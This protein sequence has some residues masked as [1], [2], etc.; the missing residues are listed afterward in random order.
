M[1]GAS[2]NDLDLLAGSGGSAERGRL[3]V[4]GSYKLHGESYAIPGN[5]IWKL[6]EEQTHLREEIHGFSW[7][8]DLRGD[9]GA[10]AF[11]LAQRWLFEW[12]AR[13]SGHRNTPFSPQITGRRLVHWLRNSRMLLAMRNARQLDQF[14]R[15]VSAHAE[16]LRRRRLVAER[17]LPRIEALAGRICAEVAIGTS[18]P[19]LSR[20]ADALA[21]ECRSAISGA[22][23]IASRNPEEL[24]RI[25]QNLTWA[26]AA[27]DA[28]KCLPG[29]DHRNG[30]EI[31]SGILRSLRHSS[32]AMPRFHGGGD[33]QVG[34]VDQ[35]IAHS[36]SGRLARLDAVM[37]YTRLRAGKTTA[38]VDVAAPPTRSA[39]RNAHASTLAFEAVSGG[40]PLIVNSGPGTGFGPDQVQAARAT[41]AHSSVEIAGVPSSRLASPVL[42]MPYRDQELSSVP[43]KV[44]VSQLPGRNGQTVIA[45]HDGYADMFG[46]T[47]MRRIDLGRAGKRLWGEDTVWTKSETDRLAYGQSLAGKE[48]D[49]LPLAARFHLH[50]D[51]L[52]E[53]MPGHSRVDVR[54]PNDEIWTFRF[55]GPARLGIEESIYLDEFSFE[56]RPSSQIVLYST[57]RSGTAQ[58]R[59]E[60]A[61]SDETA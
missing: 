40:C 24:F 56:A 50:P 42:W 55:E 13:Y 33:L 9:S 18:M 57:I 54:L 26:A 2:M 47:H 25:L 51:S 31:S 29:E 35:A 17:G 10:S 20:S 39:S 11:A 49:G 38:V 12:I 3:L 43:G 46:L 8:D 36:G 23:G 14:L 21:R 16:I 4:K 15:A 27:L 1:H 34:L 60:L 44:G 37:G 59:W 48:Q 41:A 28:A 32:G 58:I 5:D 30:L 6:A 52:V 22:S 61:C 19:D 45:S 7:L 53:M